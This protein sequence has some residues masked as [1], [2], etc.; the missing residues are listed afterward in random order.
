MAICLRASVIV[1]RKEM[2]N[3]HCNFAIVH[4]AK[5]RSGTPLLRVGEDWW[6]TPM[7]GRW[8]GPKPSPGRFWDWASMLARMRSTW[9]G[10]LAGPPLSPSHNQKDVHQLKYDITLFKTSSQKQ[11]V[12]PAFN[13]DSSL[14]LSSCTLSCNGGVA[15]RPQARS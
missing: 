11:D 1:C 6:E 13:C 8:V 12:L 9:D 7:T 2:Q 14:W 3:L 5:S 4:L 15:V 10:D